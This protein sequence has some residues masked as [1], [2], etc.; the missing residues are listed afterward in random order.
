MKISR[1]SVHLVE[2]PVPN[3]SYRISHGRDYRSFTSA[4][5]I[6][7][8]DAGLYG[9]GESCPFGAAYAAAFAGGIA[10]GIAEIAPFLFGRDPRDI[11]DINQV[12][13]ASLIGHGYVKSAVD[14]ACWDI[15]GKSTNTPIHRLIGGR[16]CE[17][18]GVRMGIPVVEPAKAIQHMDALR[19]EGFHQF[20]AKAGDNP[21]SDVARIRAIAARAT[22]E[23]VVVV[24]ANGGW[25]ADHAV[26]VM[27][28]LRDF[29]KLY[30]EQPCATYEECLAVRQRVESR[31]C[32]DE[33]LVDLRSLL[34]SHQ[35]RLA[36]AVTIKI[37]KIGGLSK[38]RLIRDVCV[39]IGM[40]MFIQDSWGS[41]IVD[42]TI[43]QLCQS[44]PPR[45]LLGG[46]CSRG[47]VG[48][49]LVDQPPKIASGRMSASDRP[50][51]GVE[52]RREILGAPAAV[53]E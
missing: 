20:N 24:D 29:P 39:E 44:T 49:T 15:L 19:A 14:I 2:L 6:V 16:L 31:I 35:D 25:R 26:Y 21:E 45:Y 40:P 1:I 34:R 13:D 48:V 22:A 33:S 53:Y 27:S 10:P 17:S 23:E 32:L 7:E 3:G 18:F 46:W 28:A 52:P 37:N 5:V 38:S 30:F 50:G 47:H 11:A 42:A 51:L 36:D 8:T 12:M 4:V 41:Q 9:I 43:A